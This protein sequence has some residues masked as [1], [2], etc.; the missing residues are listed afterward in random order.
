LPIR[1]AGI[2]PG[3]KTFDLVVLE[4]D[5]VVHEERFETP[6]IAKNP[7][8]LLNKLNSLNIDYIVAPSGYG[9]PVHNGGEVRDPRRFTVEVL[10]LSSEELVE[11][12]VLLGEPGIWVYDALAKITTEIIRIY[13]ERALF[14]PGVIHLPTVPL[15]RKINKVDMG[16][17]DKLAST[18][19]AV[20]EYYSKEGLD[21]KNINFTLLELGYGYY[22]VI[23]VKEGKVVDG[24]GGTSASTG[25]LTAGSI[26]L[27]VVA[28]VGRWERWDVFHGGILDYSG[29]YDFNELL[30]KARMSEEPYTTL[31]NH[32]IECVAKDLKK[33]LLSTPKSETVVATGRLSKIRELLEL[34][35]ERLVDLEISTLKGL[36]GAN[37]SKESAQGYAAIGSGLAGVEC[38]REVLLQMEV[39]GSCGTSVDY[40]IHPRALG[41]KERIRKAYV[42]SVYSPKLCGYS[43]L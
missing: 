31:I 8:L 4:N 12:G 29:I 41:F 21:F 1:A 23:A 25:T 18:F 34:I 5:R 35:K 37:I 36:Q 27:E 33:T 17:A 16:T 22:S 11:K 15:H 6:V 42:E 2:D 28:G 13:G 24:V 7:A 38:F 9:V 20:Y 19:L 32:F 14:T 43:L 39:N 40:M 3:T 10:L 26:D 30:R